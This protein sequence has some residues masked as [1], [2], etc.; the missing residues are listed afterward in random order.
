MRLTTLTG[1]LAVKHKVLRALLLVTALLLLPSALFAQ[2]KNTFA[3]WSE[4]NGLLEFLC[5]DG[6]SGY[7]EGDSRN[8]Y[9]I[10][11]VWSGEEVLN[12]PIGAAPGWA[13][14]KHRI[15]TVKFDPTFAE[16][17]PA[18]IAYWFDNSEI[19]SKSA[20]TLSQIEGLEY[21]NTSEVL[22][23]SNTFYRCAA[24]NR[25]DLSGF[26]TSK[27]T[28][29]QSMFMG[30]TS[31]T[32]L[33]ISSFDTRNVVNMGS[34]FSNCSALASVDVSGFNTEKA[35][36]LSAMFN[37]CSALAKID[38]GGFSTGSATNFDNMF[39]GCA[40]VKELDLSN[41]DV[42][43]VASAVNMFA[44]CSALSTIRTGETADWRSISDI[45]NMFS[46]C[47]RLMAVGKDGSTCKYQS[48][49]NLP[50][51]CTAGDG[52]FTSI[53]GYMITFVGF[54][55]ADLAYQMVDRDAATVKLNQ[56]AFTD[57]SGIK[58]FGSWNTEK[59]GSGTSYNDGETIENLGNV[60]L[61]SQ[62]GK[63]ITLCDVTVNPMS[64]TY[65][66]GECKPV[67]TVEDDSKLTLNTDFKVEYS[68]NVNAGEAA[69]TIRG[70]NAY[71]GSVTKVFTIKP[72]N[73]GIASVSPQ[74]L[75]LAF[76][77][78]VQAP[79]YVLRDGNTRLVEGVDYEVGGLDGNS[80]VGDY[81]VTFTGKGN[82]TGSTTATYTIS[83][84]NAYAVWTEG[85]ATLTFMMAEK[86]PVVGG[87]YEGSEV[88]A[89]WK[90]DDVLNS[91]QS[92]VP[93]WNSTVKAKVKTVCFDA[94]FAEASP[95]SIAYWLDNS[96]GGDNVASAGTL[97]QIKNIKNLNTSAV[98]SMRGAFYCCSKPS[99]IDVSK[100][101]TDLV[102]DMSHMFEGCSGIK[103]LNVSGF[104]TENVADMSHMFDGCSLVT[105]LAT[106][107]FDTRNVTDMSH[108]FA[109]CKSLSEAAVG[110]FNTENVADMS[111]MFMNCAAL[112]TIDLSGFITSSVTGGGMEGMFNGCKSLTELNVKGFKTDKV[113]S[114]Y[115]MF[116]N[117][118]KLAALDVSGFK[119]ASVNNFKEMFFMCESLTSLDVS[120]FKTDAAT[121]MLS[122]FDGC[123]SLSTINV[124][125]FKTDNVE[126]FGNMF[127]D[128]ANVTALKVDGFNTAKANS[129]KNM[130]QGCSSV[131]ELNVGGFEFNDQIRVDGNMDGMFANCTSL[132]TIRA[133]AG[134]DWSESCVYN[135][136]GMFEGCAALVGVGADGTI[137]KY[138]ASL[139]A[140]VSC[141]DG[142]GYFTPDNIYVITFDNNID[143]TLAYQVV[144]KPVTADV[145]LDK[146]PFTNDSF[147][148][149]AWNTASDGSGTSYKDETEIRVGQDIKLYARWGRDIELCGPNSSIQPYTYTF[150]GKNLYPTDNGGRVIV[151][152]GET[153][154]TPN[155]DYTIKYPADNINTGTYDVEIVGKGIYAGSFK[156][157]YQ[158]APYDLSDVTIEPENAVFIYNGEPQCPD[159]VLT[160][161][162]GNKLTKGTDFQFAT[163]VSN[164][165]NGDEYMVEIEGIGNYK[166]FNY[167]FYS[168]KSAFAVW[169]ESNS[170]LTFV[171]DEN[172]YKPDVSYIDGHKVTKVWSGDAIA[173]SPVDGNPA[174][175]EILGSLATVNFKESF[176]D[177]RPGSTAHWFEGAAQ[178][179]TI[180]NPENLNTSEAAS[181]AGMFAG[182]KSLAA[183]DLANFNTANVT[184]MSK[185]FDGCESLTEIN[186][187]KFNTAKVAKMDGMFANCT[188]LV[189]ICTEVGTD[190]TASQPTFAGMFAGDKK[191][192][193]IG[194]DNTS[195]L[196]ADGE[197]YPYICTNGKGYFTADN[198]YIITFADNA[199][200]KKAYQSIPK[201]NTAPVPL[202]AFPFS[203][204]RDGYVFI[205][206][207]T[208][209]D[210][211]GTAYANLAEIMVTED[212]TLYAIWKK[213]IAACKAEFDLKNAI[214]DGTAQEPK[215][216][217]TFDGY[218]LVEGKDF[219]I[220]AYSDNINA[221]DTKPYAVVRGRGDF[222][223]NAEKHFSIQP[224]N[225]AEVVVAI[226]VGSKALVYNKAAQAPSYV[227]IF[228]ELHLTEGSDY[229][230]SST[231]ENINVNDYTVTFTGQGNYTGTKTTDYSITPRDIAVATVK[232][233]QEEYEYNGA[234]VEPVATVSDGDDVLTQGKDYEISYSD[235]TNAGDAKMSVSGKGNYT[236]TLDGQTFKIIPLDLAKVTVT[237]DNPQ[238]PYNRGSQMPMFT[239]SVNGNT[240]SSAT[241]Y[242]TSGDLMMSDIGEYTVKFT[243]VE[244]GNYKGE[245]SGKYTITKLDFSDHA[246]IVFE[247]GKTNFTYT[248]ELITPAVSVKDEFGNTLVAGTDY[249]LD[250][251]GNT[252]I[253][254][255][256][257]KATGAGNY[258]GEISA[259]Y[260]ISEK[261]LNDAEVI[262]AETDFVYNGK[263][264]EPAVTVIDGI[265]EL[266]ADTDYS[267][268]YDNN[269]NASDKALVIIEGLGKY[270]QSKKEAAFTIKPC[271]IN[272]ADVTVGE[273][274]VYNGNAQIG[275]FT[276]VDANGNILTAADY[277]FGDYSSNIA[278]GEYTAEII[279]TGNYFGSIAANYTI[280]GRSIEDVEVVASE[281]Q[282]MFN[283]S[284]QTISLTVT[285]GENTLVLDE[286]YSVRYENAINAGTATAYVEGKGNYSGT[287]K[288]SVEF[289]IKPLALS[290]VDKFELENGG[291]VA[292]TGSGVMPKVDAT[293][294]YGNKLTQGTDYTVSDCSNN[295]N[296]GT[297]YD[298]TFTGIGNYAGSVTMFYDIK[299][300][301]IEDVELV[302]KDGKKEFTYTGAE[303]E[304]VEKVLDLGKE[305]AKGI[306]YQITY[307]NN[308]EPG[309][310][311]ITIVGKGDYAG[312]GSKVETFVIKRINMADVSIAM[313]Q[314][315]F[316]YN[317]KAQQPEFV[318]TD[319][320]GR[321]LVSG[322]D[323]T[324]SGND[325]NINVGEYTVTFAA[326]D[327]SNYEGDAT[328]KYSITPQQINIDDITITYG[329]A[330]F[331]YTGKAQEPEIT[332]T[333]DED[334]L[335]RDADYEIVFSDNVNAGTVKVTINGKAN[336]AGFTLPGD[337]YVIK[338]C[339]LVG[340]MV[341]ADNTTF[342]YG[343]TVKSPKYTL[344]DA[345][346]NTLAADTDYAVEGNEGNSNAGTYTVKFT[347]KGNYT[348]EISATYTIE[349]YDISRETVAV[350]FKDG[351][352]EYEYTGE[353]ISPTFDLKIN[354]YALQRDVNYT[355]SGATSRVN[356]GLYE[357][358]A[359]GIGN[360][361]GTKPVSYRILPRNI[362]GT[363]SIE[364]YDGE[365]YIETGEEIKPA[366]FVSD[367][368]STLA[369]TDYEVAYENNVNPGTAK[370]NVAGIGNYEGFAMSREF[371]ILPR[372]PVIT[373]DV[374]DELAYGNS[375]VG[376]DIK[377]VV[378]DVYR[379]R[380]VISYDVNGVL[381]PGEYT[382]NAT[383]TPNDNT[384]QESQ[385]KTT[386]VVNKREL[387]I[388][389]V[390]VIETK[391]FDNTTDATVKT[392]PTEIGN[393]INND[394]VTV[395]ATAQYE[396]VKPGRQSIT[397][398]YTIS[399]KDADK[400]IARST[401]FDGEIKKV[402]ISADAP[403]PDYAHTTAADFFGDSNPTDEH[404]F[405]AGDEIVVTF[406]N[407]K[408]NPTLVA[409]AITREGASEVIE[410]SSSAYPADNTVKVSIPGTLGYGRY[411]ATI[412]L[413]NPD[414][415]SK[416]EA[417]RIPFVVDAATS[418]DN[419][420]VRTKWDDVVYVSNEGQRFG[421]NPTFQWF[422]GSE[423]VMRPKT[424]ATGQ[425][426]Q[427]VGGLEPVHYAA[428]IVAQ[429]GEKIYTCPMAGVA[430]LKKSVAVR[431]VKVYPNPALANQD[432]TVEID[433]ANDIDGNITLMIYNG[434]GTMV[435][436]IEHASAISHITLPSGQYTGI[437]MVDGKKLTFKVIV[438]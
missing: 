394:E 32:A 67:A 70:I 14:I 111:N 245:T 308:K 137:C 35:T 358:I 211:L 383:Y 139:F 90:G 20:N 7:T 274:V 249:T 349:K 145:K 402:E 61:Y 390:E 190:W 89:F 330:D 272:N 256:D 360:F 41:F 329:N 77:G 191:L 422:K 240:L 187:K 401:K 435:K 297:G 396:S 24:L 364:F 196:Y 405:C 99:M 131:Q 410:T 303:I 80:A 280:A 437:A 140:P 49:K 101:N 75:I 313:S 291:R 271:S 27:V 261:T 126:D 202:S 97:F 175:S 177:V 51:V 312:N 310:A 407:V 220:D 133:K 369:D 153:T 294:R 195:C 253:G 88:T 278:A 438:Y 53:A 29:M 79:T 142:S 347:G 171:L 6:G 397:V 176:A 104:N 425:Y 389:G 326:V 124:S 323:F 419:P 335:V 21:L 315:E 11:K 117:C 66:G 37:R 233:E 283:G 234:A 333:F 9:R 198:F 163:D 184:D 259:N 395:T 73:I 277:T 337:D 33:D 154:L 71:A 172:G 429:N 354:G 108:M 10:T 46:G 318:L 182:C 296:V 287:A 377:A 384:T 352:S 156:L 134:T 301:G 48:G 192:V 221:S 398:A 82:Y 381:T 409:T 218:T 415:D 138:D 39:N 157:T 235:N 404:H 248:G 166:G 50:Y 299:P 72:A 298:I 13:S 87:N 16:A 112:R 255:Y 81:T 292:Y 338:P 204:M 226:T 293:D 237:P 247:N 317:K 55:D 208:E 316:P 416:A 412:T 203:F 201:S 373:F 63:D 417:A 135:H 36:D 305:L 30:C 28:D 413:E 307:T 86:E 285:D 164:N 186:V 273:A 119:T 83:A 121:T 295:I 336:Y 408:G 115:A 199:E 59:N 314:S 167:A 426:Y 331:T 57:P 216:T 342:T 368:T 327:G 45:S 58:I 371:T 197:D 424:G 92:G 385:G 430:S 132:A 205:N 302:F 343:G 434:N 332:V 284:E 244:P 31:L 254:S 378:A 239:L 267:V 350:E 236:G 120:G 103:T 359:E 265:T 17:R 144:A 93:A 403:K 355:V 168:I 170:A 105:K 357:I 414:G 60:I 76:N 94:S 189:S 3:L 346:G 431:S 193:G 69:I 228:G 279:G 370:V 246:S 432:F 113:T 62:W 345:N 400:Y 109:G 5:T 180:L 219:V 339:A 107:N 212:V 127:N 122:M 322:D 155:V 18:S 158:I 418:G 213:D 100:F 123:K 241:D 229:T 161:G 44:A 169:T 128:C 344:T 26:N 4:G 325:G 136:D 341:S 200:G 374:D 188:S 238:L 376:E 351:V 43:N 152:D 217:L 269:T 162:N 399:G 262:F 391:D 141:K 321:T 386:V 367:G 174:W 365:L 268:T 250:N 19:R 366:I 348:G 436:R 252:E 372:K 210:G 243:A 423:K 266:V 281:T 393:V 300:R 78:N 361:T 232:T 411:V 106:D 148:F 362:S 54:D 130:F 340:E 165:V 420:I 427:E 214:Y 289:E 178:L 328:R 129:F 388:A 84:Q 68:N 42:A 110:G 309:T 264:H 275:T 64:Y 258:T 146:N 8:G 222:A 85:D 260:R 147:N 12:T 25:L 40:L 98:T 319:Q 286:D 179:K 38:V 181:M 380:G 206:W 257:I 207:N 65:S 47:S 23:M 22:S 159:F 356:A 375:L 306:D 173:K 276:I 56:N 225:L 185:M 194:S 95:K 382:I 118:P 406:E 304:P 223:G 353:E 230:T 231:D 96:D 52:Y 102:A 379:S 251:P 421:S 150:T 114:L 74:R 224:R 116:A 282:K 242:T 334:V 125:K 34:M 290:S 2:G 183:I 15:K 387:M 270:N 263:P 288:K 227:L 160:D 392:Q 363:A 433:N 320:N 1:I 149:V 311:L 324:M 428:L 215:F 91:P 209:P 143:N 151:K